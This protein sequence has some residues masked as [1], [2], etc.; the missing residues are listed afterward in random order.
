MR[1]L[2]SY[3]PWLVVAENWRRGWWVE[4]EHRPCTFRCGGKAVL[5][6]V[7]VQTLETRARIAKRYYCQACVERLPASLKEGVK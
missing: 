2:N 3:A 7:A 5:Q 4:S 6:L 1:L